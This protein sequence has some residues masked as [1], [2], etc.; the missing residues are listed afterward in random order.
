MI[1]YAPQLP[2]S[3]ELFGLDVTSLPHVPTT[4]LWV[5]VALLSIVITGVSLVLYYHWLRFAFGNRMVIFAGL[6]YTAVILAGLAI[7]VSSISY[8]G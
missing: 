6:L 2:R 3:G 5:V 4:A 1:E 8:Y 7:M